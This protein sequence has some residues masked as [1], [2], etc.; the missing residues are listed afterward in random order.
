MKRLFLTSFLLIA[1]IDCACA[2]PVLKIIPLKHRFAQDLVPVI[3][4]LVGSAGSVSGFNE[5]LIINAEPSAI[6]EIETVIRNL[7][8]ERRNWRMTV[9]HAGSGTRA[10]TRNG[11]SGEI[12]KDIRVSMPD[13]H[14]RTR[15]GVNVELND[16]SRTWSES[17]NIE[18]QI[19]DGE[20]G[21]IRVGQE[22]PYTAT[23]IEL[24]RRHARLIQEVQ[25]R[26]VST[27][28][29]V[30][31][32]QLGNQV[33]IEI[34]P[35]ISALNGQGSIDFTELS[36][37]IRADPGEWVDLGA[38]LSARDEVSRA[39]LQEGNGSQQSSTQL[40]IRVD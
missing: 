38:T 10:E 22:I 27:G 3:Q 28:F 31:P 19:L 30:R 35:R 5:Q 1:L 8:V 18:L 33:D 25:W 14:G 20:S 16:R 4:P 2:A 40:R 7:D 23:W 12:G 36:T 32:R 26:D 11:V 9:S 15:R 37:H 21:F 29:A 6:A 39:I 24:T 17:G 34:V 13:R